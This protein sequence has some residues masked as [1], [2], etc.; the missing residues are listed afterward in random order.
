MSGATFPTEVMFN[1]SIDVPAVVT[2]V[3]DGVTTEHTIR[4]IYRNAYSMMKLLGVDINEAK[5]RIVC[6][7]SDMDALYAYKR[8]VTIGTEVFYM[9]TKEVNANGICRVILSSDN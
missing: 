9:N 3:A 1:G 2:V 6:K 7:T 4:V 8:R 5:P